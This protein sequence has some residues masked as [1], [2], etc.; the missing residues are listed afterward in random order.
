MVDPVDTER[1]PEEEREAT[2][3]RIIPNL[4]PTFGGVGGF[5][6][7]GVA[8]GNPGVLPGIPIGV[9]DVPPAEPDDRDEIWH[10]K[11]EAEAEA[12]IEKTEFKGGPWHRSE[13]GGDAKP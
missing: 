12:E 8:G 13:P 3:A 10:Y 9:D 2:E 4:G 6:G 7:A 5:G 1:E 11:T